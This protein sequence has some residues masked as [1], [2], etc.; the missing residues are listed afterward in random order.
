LT[1][2]VTQIDFT[3][4]RH[5][6]LK[7]N[8]VIPVSFS[9]NILTQPVEGF[10][11]RISLAIVL[12]LGGSYKVGFKYGEGARFLGLVDDPFGFLNFYLMIFLTYRDRF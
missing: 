11:R 9:V 12:V 6:P 8:S 3:A 2:F 4:R 5:Q 1:Q 10:L 7:P